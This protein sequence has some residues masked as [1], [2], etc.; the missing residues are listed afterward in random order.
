[1]IPLKYFLQR[2]EIYLFH[3]ML[4]AQSYKKFK[5][6][7]LTSNSIN[8]TEKCALKV[9]KSF[10]ILIPGLSYSFPCYLIILFYLACPLPVLLT[11]LAPLFL[12]GRIGHE[13]RNWQRPNLTSVA[14][15]LGPRPLIVFVDGITRAQLSPEVTSSGNLNL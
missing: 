7:I 6:L 13:Q 11:R 1:M 8:L 15:F 12:W 2:D 3:A 14:Q 9:P 5:A 10:I 4:K